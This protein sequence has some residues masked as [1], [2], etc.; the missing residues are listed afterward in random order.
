MTVELQM[1]YIPSKGAR[2]SKPTLLV[3]CP[4]PSHYVRLED[5]KRLPKF[6][7]SVVVSPAREYKKAER[8]C[9]QCNHFGKQK[10]HSII[11]EYEGN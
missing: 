6:S 1:S 7:S 11:C 8:K 2:G 4:K 9:H 3:S 10:F 5:G